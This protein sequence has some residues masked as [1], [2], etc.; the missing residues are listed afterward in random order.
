MTKLSIELPFLP[1]WDNE[2]KVIN[3][4]YEDHVCNDVFD[5]KKG[6]FWLDLSC[7]IF[8]ASQKDTTSQIITSEKP[9]SQRYSTINPAEP[10]KSVNKKE[11][12]S[13]PTKE[14]PEKD[15]KG[16][17]HSKTGKPVDKKGAPAKGADPK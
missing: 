13:K 3:F 5:R 7:Y 1:F 16:K 10:S 9:S 17:E 12:P 6:C 4:K 2:K 15:A 11:A 14:V 8:N